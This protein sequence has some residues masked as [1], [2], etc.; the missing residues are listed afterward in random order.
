MFVANSKVAWTT[1]QEADLL[2]RPVLT[3][4]PTEGRPPRSQMSALMSTG[5]GD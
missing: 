3:S 5:D 1:T 2:A 4:S